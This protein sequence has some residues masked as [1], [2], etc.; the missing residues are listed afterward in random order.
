MTPTQ[1]ILASRNAYNAV[2]DS[3]FSDDEILGLLYD[4]CLEMSRESLVIERVYS[5]STVIGTQEYDFPANTI[6]IKRVTYD[7]RK[8]RPISFREDDTI[9]GLNQANTTQ[10]TPEYYYQWNETIGLRA[11][12]D[13]VKTLQIYSYNEPA[14]I[15]TTS[16]IEIPSMFHRGLVYYVVA[17]QAAKDLNFSA[18]QYYQNK[19][20]KVLSDAK[21]WAR[22]RKRTDS[23][24]NVQDEESLVGTYL[25]PF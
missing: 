21:K 12:P 4:A 24:A 7:G 2:G 10:G 19:W 18:A 13:A 14:V 1:V 3:F 9:T 6:A 20:V 5:T 25:G 8:L 22:K 15:A 17:E 16:T 11:I 23:P